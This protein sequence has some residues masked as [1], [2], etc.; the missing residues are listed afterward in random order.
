MEVSNDNK[1]LAF[2]IGLFIGIYLIFAKPVLNYF[3][4]TK[5]KGVKK[6]QTNEQNPDSPFKG[7][8]WKKYIYVPVSLGGTAIKGGKAVNSTVIQ[9]VTQGADII[10]NAMGYISDD[11]G[12]VKSVFSTLKTK[13]EVS[14]LA[15]FFT[16]KYKTDFLEYLR[17]GKDVMP[18]NG[19]SDS[20]LNTLINYVENLPVK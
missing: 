2:K 13:S 7:A 6:L 8:L 12:A 20:D 16:E 14:L 10:F 5:G 18:Q 4:I 11:E 15:W 3:G 9:N 19:L 17:T 1:N